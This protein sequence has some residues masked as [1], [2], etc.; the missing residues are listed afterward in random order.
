[1]KWRLEKSWWKSE[2]PKVGFLKI[3]V[4]TILVRYTK[5]KSESS[6]MISIRN[7]RGDITTNLQKFKKNEYYEQ[8]YANILFRWK[9]NS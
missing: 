5:N 7:E 2:K 6:E 3:N 8:L 9:T 1:M 4:V